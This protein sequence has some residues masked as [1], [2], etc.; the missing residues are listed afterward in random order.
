MAAKIE[1][2]S[3]PPEDAL[4]ELGQALEFALEHP[5]ITARGKLLFSAPRIGDRDP[6]SRYGGGCPRTIEGSWTL[7][8]LG[9][10][11]V[12]VQE[13]ARDLG[14]GRAGRR[15]APRRRQ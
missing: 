11:A 3:V 13:R 12:L 4:V 7:P 8:D 9:E 1:S 2:D 10:L 15:P 6:I 14:G 5:T